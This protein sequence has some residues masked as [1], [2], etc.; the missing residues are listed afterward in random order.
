MKVA[1]TDHIRWHLHHKQKEIEELKEYINSLRDTLVERDQIIEKL[2][3]CGVYVGMNGVNN[4]RTGNWYQN[5]GRGQA[6]YN[7][8]NTNSMKPPG[9]QPRQGM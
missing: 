2:N 9:L 4:Q 7:Q 1:L 5:A 6:M 8:G 3:A